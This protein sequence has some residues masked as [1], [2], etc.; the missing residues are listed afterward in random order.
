[1]SLPPLPLM[2]CGVV[3]VGRSWNF[4]RSIKNDMY[5][6]LAKILSKAHCKATVNQ[7]I[8]I[9]FDAKGIGASER[10][11]GPSGNELGLPFA[12]FF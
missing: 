4:V 10:V 2:C 1:M 7:T 11:S 5:P 9:D 6:V 12:L 3:F 8:R